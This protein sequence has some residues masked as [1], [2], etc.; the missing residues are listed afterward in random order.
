MAITETI[1]CNQALQRMGQ[2]LID[3][4]DGASANEKKCANL[5]DQIRDETLVDGPEKGWK[6][7]KT[8]YHGIDGIDIDS[9]TI[10]AFTNLVTDV[11][12]TVT[13]THAFAAGDMVII[14]DT[15]NYDGT[16]DI[17]SVSTTVSFVITKAFVDDDATGTAYWTS[18][19]Y[20]YRF[21]IPTSL[22]V[23][24]VKVGGIELTD[25]IERGVYILTNQESEKVDMDIIRAITDVTLFPTH[26]IRVLVLKLAIGLHYSMTQDLKAIELLGIEL[27]LAIPKAIAIDERGKYVEESSS[28]WENVGNTQEVRS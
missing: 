14:D 4:I 6:F 15:T 5:F 13:A 23:L 25:W 12:T 11:T 21:P 28:S 3:S 24:A 18:A 7:A 27:D 19:D 17:V 22:A 1:I 26:F 8:A 16:Y 10:T 2:S 20:G 9:Y